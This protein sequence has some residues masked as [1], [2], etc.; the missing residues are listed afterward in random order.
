MRSVAFE[1][2]VKYGFG[3]PWHVVAVRPSRAEAAGIAA[4]GFMLADPV[5]RLPHQVRVLAR[6][7]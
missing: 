4:R 6:P 2:Q 7:T 3:E 5:G 1:A